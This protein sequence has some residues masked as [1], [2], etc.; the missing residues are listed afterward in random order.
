[1]TPLARSWSVPFSRLIKSS[2]SSSHSTCLRVTIATSGSPRATLA[3]TSIWAVILVVMPG[4]LPLVMLLLVVPGAA[5]LLASLVLLVAMLGVVPLPVMPL[6]LVAGAA[7]PAVPILVSLPLGNRHF[8]LC[9]KTT[10]CRAVFAVGCG[11]HWHWTFRGSENFCFSHCDEV[12]VEQMDG[13]WLDG[14]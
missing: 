1:M 2:P 7:T 9:R 3:T 14:Y 8:F 11:G 4:L 13:R 12:V 5:L 10:F 6:A